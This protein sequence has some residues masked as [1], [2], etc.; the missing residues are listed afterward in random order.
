M[1]GALW[2]SKKSHFHPFSSMSR[3]TKGLLGFFFDELKME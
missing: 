3:V 1:L 2:M